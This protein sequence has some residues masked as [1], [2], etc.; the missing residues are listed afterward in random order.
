[1]FPFDVLELE[2]ATMRMLTKG[3]SLP[4]TILHAIHQF[5]NIP[6]VASPPLCQ[7]GPSSPHRPTLPLTQRSSLEIHV[8]GA[9]EYDV[10]GEYGHVYEELL[11]S[12][13]ACTRLTMRFIGPGLRDVGTFGRRQ[14]DEFEVENC[15]DC[16]ARGHRTHPRLAP[17]L[18]PQLAAHDPRGDTSARPASRPT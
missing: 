10:F 15:D 17:S 6:T 16:I 4:L 18:V 2:L 8:L 14:E 7:A 11:H 12:L 13:P 5:D 3:L 1:M 9:T